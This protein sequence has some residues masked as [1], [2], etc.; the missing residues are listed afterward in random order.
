MAAYRWV[1][2]EPTTISYQT[3]TMVK[4][5]NLCCHSDASL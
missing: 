1:A 2:D 5:K 3:L 4:L